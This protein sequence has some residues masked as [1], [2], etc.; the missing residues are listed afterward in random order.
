MSLAGLSLRDLEYVVAVAEL[1]HCG[2]AAERC[3]VSQPALSGQI[4]RLEQ[5][6]GLEIF[7]RSRKVCVT[8]R[9]A[10]LVE[11]ARVVLEEARHFVELA[12]EHGNGLAGPLC[13]GTIPTIGPYLLPYILRPLR[14]R[15]P[16]LELVLTEALTPD[17]LRQLRD[18]DL[19]AAILS[20]PLP[21]RGLRMFELFFEPFV[22][23]HPPGHAVAAR[24]PVAVEDLDQP[25]LL[26]LEE[27]HCLRDQALSLCGDGAHPSRRHATGLEMLKHMVAAGDGF[28]IL[29]LLAATAPPGLNELVAFTPLSG[30]SAGRHVALVC[31]SSDPRAG[32]LAELARAITAAV[33]CDTGEAR[34]PAAFPGVMVTAPSVGGGAHRPIWPSTNS[35]RL[36]E[37]WRPEAAEKEGAQHFPNRLGSD[38]A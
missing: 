18:G 37:A 30:A 9:G 16:Q 25:G 14:A 29:P 15:Y 26:L 6:I 4:R 2:R 35:N 34:D 33:C 13:L 17:L 23:I 8:P 38:K 28:S 20:P 31:R 36:H 5:L 24:P 22:M 27:G 1:R 32:A 21:D 11:Q 7:E 3:A 19:D 10:A 12:R